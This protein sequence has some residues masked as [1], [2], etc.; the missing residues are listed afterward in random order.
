M[1]IRFKPL[2]I[3]IPQSTP[4]QY[5]LLEREKSAEVLT[6][7][8]S[9]LEEPFVLAVDSPW[10]SGKT[11]F[12]KMWLQSLRNERLPCL[13]FN[14]W[15]NDF[16]DSPLVSLIGEI[17]EAIKDLRLGGEQEKTARRA[18]EKAKKSGAVLAKVA[19]PAAVKLATA[20]LLDLSA[21]KAEDL[22]NLAEELA[23][24]Q[25][26]KYQADKKTIGHF[27]RDLADLV[28]TLREKTGN[29]AI[30]PIV[31]VID[32][33]DRCRPP[34]GV[35][36][37]EKVKHLFSVEGL[38]F[39]LAIDRQ[40]LGESVRCL[41]GQG[42]DADNYLRRFIDLEYRLPAPNIEQFV[43]AQFAR[44]ELEQLIGAKK[45]RTA[46]DVGNLVKILSQL[47][48]VFRFQLRTQEHCFTQLA[49]VLHTTP[50]GSFVYAFLLV[51][52]LCLRIANRTLYEE[53]CSGHA[54]P[55]EVAT[56]IRKF[57]GGD[58]FMDS[59]I[60]NILGAYLIFGMRDWKS[61][62]VEVTRLRQTADDQNIEAAVRERAAAISKCFQWIPWESADD[63]TGYLYKKIE[64]SQ[65]F[66]ETNT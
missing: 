56:F 43:K 28:S 37:L 58:E 16:S 51:P 54:R 1:A 53:Y 12:L 61:R 63:V 7:F 3:E 47:F 21:L 44:F 39:V 55:T 29:K 66:I 62:E 26:E 22:A 2:P 40:Q 33:L 60:G 41:Y 4:F 34:Y 27:R 15:Q 19:L 9:R 65:P 46:E 11:T 45:G 5:D 42:L 35:E 48:A 6:Q 64:L 14:A 32:E 57:R 38:V 31:F 25:I 17:G 36:L 50:P 8:V 24:Q 18:F 52:L 20:G 30:K 10:G 23:K 49:V 59:R 13:Y